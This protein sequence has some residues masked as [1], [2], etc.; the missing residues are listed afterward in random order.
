MP[1]VLLSRLIWRAAHFKEGKYDMSINVYGGYGRTR[2]PKNIAGPDGTNAKDNTAYK[3]ENQRF[4]IIQTGAHTVTKLEADLAAT[5]AGTWV[6][7]PLG[8]AIAANTIKI[9][10]IAGADQVR[11]QITGDNDS[12]YLACSTF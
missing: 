8:G 3:T 10:E 11:I 12:A 4:L 2:R 1:E 9:V 5:P 7:I 6:D